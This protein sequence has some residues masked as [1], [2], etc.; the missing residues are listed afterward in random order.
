MSKVV[1][2]GRNANFPKPYAKNA[3][4]TEP[5]AKSDTAK[6]TFSCERT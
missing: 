5:V 2:N 6:I 4:L 3:Q 1:V